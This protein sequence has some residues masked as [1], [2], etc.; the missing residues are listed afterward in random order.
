M[1]FDDSRTRP[2][3]EV[4]VRKMLTTLSQETSS[5]QELVS[6]I[7]KLEERA[8]IQ[9]TPS[10]LFTNFTNA[11][12][13]DLFAKIMEAEI[14]EFSTALKKANL[15]WSIDQQFKPTKND[16]NKTKS[17]SKEKNKDKPK[18]KEFYCKNHGQNYSHNTE[19]SNSGGRKTKKVNHID[20]EKGEEEKPKRNSKSKSNSDYEK[21]QKQINELRAEKQ[22][23]EDEDPKPD[24]PKRKPKR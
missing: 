24:K 10:E 11:L 7:R 17:D 13:K 6:N 5:P 19:D 9:L 20:H 18:E 12:N 1:I 3:E 16:S 4:T 2:M 21:L 23:E 14:K 8:A 15:L 22:K